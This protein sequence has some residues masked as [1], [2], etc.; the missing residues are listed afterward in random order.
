M[1]KIIVFLLV[2]Y[3]GSLM[4]Q[5]FPELIEQYKKECNE[6]VQ[7]TIIQTGI[8]TCDL[9]P[10]KA[11]NGKILHYVIAAADTIWNTPEC[12]QYKEYGHF[13][14][15]KGI[16]NV[17]ISLTDNSDE[18]LLSHYINPKTPKI[19]LSISRKHICNVKRRE[20]ELF[21]DHFWE[22][23]RKHY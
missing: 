22:W 8:V 10:V 14:F 11:A 19:S 17:G 20:V 12:S 6:I 9:L 15:S 3:S 5:S 16:W 21:G 13:R 2:I 7:D 23:M 4:S 18:L 1:K